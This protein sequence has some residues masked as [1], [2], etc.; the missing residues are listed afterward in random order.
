LACTLDDTIIRFTAVYGPT[1][2]ADREKL[3]QELRQVKP[4]QQLPWMIMEDFNVT[5]KP[6]DRSNQQHTMHEMTQ[7]MNVVSSFELMDLQLQPNLSFRVP[8]LPIVLRKTLEKLLNLRESDLR[9]G[10]GNG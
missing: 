6:M 8:N 3:Y 1:R 9:S 5:L 7:F 4:Q 2:Q 10:P